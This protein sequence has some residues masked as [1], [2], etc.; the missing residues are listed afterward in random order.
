MCYKSTNSWVPIKEWGGDF[1]PPLDT[2][3]QVWN[4]ERGE[5][6]QDTLRNCSK[7]DISTEKEG[8]SRESLQI[9]AKRM[10]YKSAISSALIDYAK[11]VNSENLAQYWA[12]YKCGRSLVQS[13]NKYIKQEN[14]CGSR[15]CPIC[16]NIR[17]QKVADLVL[18]TID[19][20]KEWVMLTLTNSNNSLNYDINELG[21]RLEI[22][23]KWFNKM[24]DRWRKRGG[25]IS[26]IISLEIIPPGYKKNTKEGGLYYA[27]FHPH[28]H[29]LITLEFAEFLK[30]Q[31]L[32]TF[33]NASEKN[34]KIKKVSDYLKNKNLT[35]TG[36]L[37][38]MIREVVKYSLKACLPKIK[39]DGYSC[40][41]VVGV[42]EIITLMKSRKR[43]K[44]WGDFVEIKKEVDSVENKEIKELDLNKVVYNDLPVKDTGEMKNTKD[45]KGN[46]LPPAPDFVKNVI[47][48]FDEKRQDYFYIDEWG[49]EYN[50]TG[51]KK[52]KI[53][54]MI[55]ENRKRVKYIKT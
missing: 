23:Q 21:K 12:V 44:K 45:W 16:S 33:K 49:K 20:K 15:L 6:N 46:E 54:L 41:N 24:R 3:E 19:L 17:S 13:E 18:S 25:D 7:N 53:K 5:V 14:Y 55:C 40:L 2:N 48:V 11:G 38:N 30:K 51:N 36:A 52:R 4:F 35:K 32:E 26:A 50:L 29:I 1:C 37:R 39:K 10:A 9:K 47:W 42:D 34:Q 28:Y 22:E 8:V 27:D 31:W 43:L